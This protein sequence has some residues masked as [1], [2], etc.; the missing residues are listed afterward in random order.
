MRLG[1][2]P[3]VAL[4][5]CTQSGTLNEEPPAFALT[6]EVPSAGAFLGDVTV[7]RVAGVVSPPTAEVLVEGVRVPVDAEGAFEAEVWLEDALRVDVQAL[8]EGEELREHVSVFTGVDPLSSWPG[9]LSAR[10]TPS[11]L[12]GLGG[13]LG[14]YVDGL[15]EDAIPLGFLPSFS[16]GGVGFGVDSLT[17][18]E[19]EVEVQPTDEG[20][21]ADV[22]IPDAALNMSLTGSVLGIPFTWPASIGMS[23]LGIGGRVDLF[24]DEAGNLMLAFDEPDIVIGDPEIDF[25]VAGFGWLNSL[26]G[27]LVGGDG[28]L[29]GLLGAALA[30]APP[31]QVLQG[32][33]AFEQDLLGMPLSLA[34]TDFATDADG[35]GVQASVG[36]GE[37]LPPSVT[38]DFPIPPGLPQVDLVLA[39]H[40]GLVQGLV[41]SSIVESLSGELPIE[42]F[43]G[44]LNIPMSN[45]PGGD[46]IPD[47]EGWCMMLDPGEARLGRFVSGLEPMASIFLPEAEVTM[48]LRIRGEAECQP[49]LQA[50]VG[51][52][53]DVHADGTAISLDISMDDAFVL[54]YGA[55]DVDPVVVGDAFVGVLDGVLG[56]AGGFL[57]FDLGEL[58][59]GGGLPGMPGGDQEP[60]GDAA[61]LGDLLGLLDIRFVAAHRLEE[62]PF[63]GVELIGMDLFGEPVP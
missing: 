41:G 7:A 49:W 14:A 17:R 62:E 58:L 35:L 54:V 40:E 27:N 28:L 20:L 56:L 30:D 55:E 47:N 34:L 18:G 31:I 42:A 33:L 61:G 46:Q 43:S 48:G 15:F 23:E 11:G 16:F 25:N 6:L 24:L 2:L 39:A 63:V 53:L 26:L 45:L 12:A 51:V 10:V 1:L 50:L 21:V 13:L 38:G 19:I 32:P 44:L 4:M 52:Q 60:A 29:E 5:G 57:S 36:M 9:A 59:A 22:V 8:Y 3:I 37:A